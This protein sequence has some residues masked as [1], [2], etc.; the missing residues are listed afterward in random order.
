M[1]GKEDSWNN[2][3]Q[4][5]PGSGSSFP[6]CVKLEGIQRE[7]C[8]LNSLLPLMLSGCGL[9]GRAVYVLS[10]GANHHATPTILVSHTCDHK[11][12]ARA[13]FFFWGGGN[14]SH[15]STPVSGPPGASTST[16]LFLFGFF[17]WV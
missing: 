13:G 15:F 1:I 16:V 8:D 4:A 11:K 14:L 6:C 17:K 10:R 5:V 3:F 7:S 2:G 12:P 9:L